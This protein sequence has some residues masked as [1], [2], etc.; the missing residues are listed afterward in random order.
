MIEIRLLK[1]IQVSREDH[2][3]VWQPLQSVGKL[4]HAHQA[5]SVSEGLQYKDRKSKK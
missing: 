2:R 4:F 1:Q 5:W 3:L